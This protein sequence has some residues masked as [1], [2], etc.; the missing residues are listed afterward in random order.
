[1]E[2]QIVTP[3]WGENLGFGSLDT[4]DGQDLHLNSVT[5]KG[6]GRRDPCGLRNEMWNYLPKTNKVMKVPPS[7]MMGSWMGSDFHE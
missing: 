1:M 2:M 6:E 3:H 7:M 4:G 5:Q